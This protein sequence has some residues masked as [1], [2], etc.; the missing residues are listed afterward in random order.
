METVVR[1]TGA[2]SG[3]GAGAGVTEAA[4]AEVEADAGATG[5]GLGALHGGHRGVT[6]ASM[7]ITIKQINTHITNH[8][9]RSHMF[10]ASAGVSAAIYS[11]I[12]LEMN[13]EDI[14]HRTALRL[15]LN[16]VSGSVVHHVA[17]LKRGLE[18]NGVKCK[19]MK[20]FCVIPSTLEACAHYWVREENSGLDF[21][22]GFKVACLKSP[23]LQ[24]ISPVLLESL[25]EGVKRSDMEEV[26]I[27]ADNEDLF[28]LYHKNEKEFWKQAPADVRQF[29][30]KM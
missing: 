5:A 27:R 19:M 30:I 1:S 24:T 29:S 3:D 7:M 9:R 28:E 6:F 23:E 12:K 26:L 10:V 2:A 4:G 25:P 14:V 11:S 21:D 8:F 17:I 22:I 16:K 15:K 18:N 13:L 20:G